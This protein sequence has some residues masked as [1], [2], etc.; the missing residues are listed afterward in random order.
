M[1]QQI[2]E[3][4]VKS[5]LIWKGLSACLI[6]ALV[7]VNSISNDVAVL[8]S[9]VEQAETSINKM[10]ENLKEVSTT[11]TQNAAKLEA[12]KTSLQQ[13][14]TAITDTRSDIRILNTRL[15]GLGFDDGPRAK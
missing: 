3:L 8:K 11:T 2:S 12:I 13:I 10:S 7:W 6:P 15:L 14:H 1:S 5:D 4:S 9:R